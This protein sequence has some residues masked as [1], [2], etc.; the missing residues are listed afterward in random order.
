MNCAKTFSTKQSE[1]IKSEGVKM[2]QLKVKWQNCNHIIGICIS[3]DF[4]SFKTASIINN[5]VACPNWGSTFTW[6]KKML[7]IINP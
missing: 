2:G 4:K 6:N 1:K 3:M 7:L 5:K